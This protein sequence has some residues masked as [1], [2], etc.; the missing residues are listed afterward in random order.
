MFFRSFFLLVFVLPLF[1]Q[2]EFSVDSGW[3]EAQNQVSVSVNLNNIQEVAGFQFLLRDAPDFLTVQE[4]LPTERLDGFTVV[5]HEQTDGS[6]MFAVYNLN[7]AI[8]PAGNGPV[9]TIGFAA[10]SVFTQVE[11]SLLLSEI[12]A[13]LA[14]AHEIPS[15]GQN[16][17][18]TIIPEEGILLEPEP[19]LLSGLTSGTMN[20][21]MINEEPVAGLQFHMEL[22]PNLADIVDIST[23]ERTEG[24]VISSGW[25]NVL[26]FSLSGSTIAPGS[27]P[28]M[29]FELSPLQETGSGE[30]S[31]SEIILS[32]ISGELLPARS[33]SSSI[34]V[35]EGSPGDINTDAEINI[36]DIVLLVGF[37]MGTEPTEYE[38]WASDLNED[39]SLNVLDVVLLVDVILEN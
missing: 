35:G 39:N 33:W 17:V 25:G 2:A 36:L 3:V 12:V 19:V 6:E 13:G 26:G 24:W 22:G 30:I 7:G 5:S 23:T 15:S 29:M 1:A 4:I 32:D 9:L 38:F 34:M 37:I 10:D 11:V 28:V 16:G 20:L 8:L 21:T 14:N 31:L 18:I 27:G